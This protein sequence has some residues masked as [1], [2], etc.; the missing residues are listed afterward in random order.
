VDDKSLVRNAA[1]AHQVRDAKKKAKR[2]RREEL[3]DV[4]SVL[5]L[6]A[7]RRLVWRLMKQA[8]TFGTSFGHDDRT[9]SFREGERNVGNWVLHEVMEADPAALLDMMKAMMPATEQAAEDTE[10]EDSP[11]A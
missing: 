7:G 5:D 2:L 3:D 8:R 10:K 1:D 4:K 9:T 6:P 11:D